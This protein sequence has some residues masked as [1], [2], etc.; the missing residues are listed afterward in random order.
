MYRIEEIMS[1]KE[2]IIATIFTLTMLLLIAS[3]IY[4]LEK[5]KPEGHVFRYEKWVFQIFGK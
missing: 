3:A 5:N 2:K 4:T 1:K